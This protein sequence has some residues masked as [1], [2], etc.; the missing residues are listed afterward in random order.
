M[1]PHADRR[2]DDTGH[3]SRQP[4]I[5]ATRKV[6]AHRP[7]SNVIDFYSALAFALAWLT[8]RD[9]I[10]DRPTGLT[11]TELEPGIT[12]HPSRT[13][14]STSMFITHNAAPDWMLP[15]LLQLCSRHDV[16]RD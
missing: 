6:S 9:R 10:A 8:G 5:F 2:P 3:Q 16:S 13:G 11:G 7:L 4:G 15:G 14:R 12:T 1:V